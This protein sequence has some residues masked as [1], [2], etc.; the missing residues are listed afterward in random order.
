MQTGA[1]GFLKGQPVTFDLPA[2]WKL[3]AMVEPREGKPPAS[4]EAMV[5]TALRN[6]VGMPPL[7]E[8]LRRPNKRVAIISDDQTRPTPVGGVL[9]PLL[10]ELNRLGV[11]D[12][13][14]D[15]VIAPGTHRMPLEADLQKKLG[16]E[17]LQRLRVSVHD[18][19][20]PDLVHLGT[21]RRGTPMWCNKVVAEAGLKIGIGLCNPHY[22]AG[23]S[24]GA[25][26]ILPG[27]S[28]RETAK[29]NHTWS[30]DPNCREGKME[31]NPI[32]EDIV[33]MARIVGL[34]MKID[35]V[36]NTEMQVYKVTAG[37]MEKAQK[38]AAR[39][40]LELYG[41]PVPKMADVTITSSYP[42]EADL[43]QSGKAVSLA[44][45]VTMPGG[46][47]IVLSG[48]YDG[49]GPMLYETLSQSPEPDTIVQ[50]IIEGKAS[51]TGGPMAAKFRHILKTKRILLV[52]D[53]LPEAKIRD[54][55]MDYA[56][57]IGEALHKASKVYPKAE[58]IVL[59]VGGSTFPYIQ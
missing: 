13:D 20:A 34:D 53:G 31:G 6:P 38:E 44:D 36:M 1:K 39:A 59:P 50:W 11:K 21:T 18:P 45:C 30:S 4:L 37:D 42:L 22:F 15:V 56:P 28:G 3:L 35:L 10:A 49:A 2:G 48:C 19:D 43:I 12:E 16:P 47:I 27:V 40:V 57:S 52:T 33:E 24:G 14:I 9:L 26:I 41:V 32:W 55:E 17:V 5:V 54:M 29:A 46:T 58:A 7:F 8:I 51:P 25:K 23:Y